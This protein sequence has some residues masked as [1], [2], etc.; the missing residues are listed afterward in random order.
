MAG[1]AASEGRRFWPVG[2][3]SHRVL[4]H[5]V[6]LVQVAEHINPSVRP[7]RPLLLTTELSRPS[8]QGAQSI[9][10]RREPLTCGPNP[11]K[12]SRR[13]PGRPAQLRLVPPP[14]DGRRIEMWSSRADLT[15]DFAPEDTRFRESAPF[16]GLPALCR[17]RQLETSHGMTSGYLGAP[18]PIRQTLSA[19]DS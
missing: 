13:W 8:A 1:A 3:P 18:L 19:T 14:L 16:A 9:N 6:Y 4:K 12:S 10:P 17:S 11:P 7:L 15:D 2:S 5:L